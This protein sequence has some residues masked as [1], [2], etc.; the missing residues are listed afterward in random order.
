MRK[1]RLILWESIASITDNTMSNSLFVSGIS[2]AFVGLM[3]K[4][5]T[6]LKEGQA[7]TLYVVDLFKIRHQVEQSEWIGLK[8]IILDIGA[9]EAS[10][11]FGFLGYML[12][13]SIHLFALTRI[14]KMEDKNKQ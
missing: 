13:M 4:I 14:T 2:L 3:I 10:L 11:L 8:E 12:F 1:L 9:I 7:M 6:Y 5:I